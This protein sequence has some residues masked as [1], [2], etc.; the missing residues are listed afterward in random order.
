MVDD[1]RIV[2][3]ETKERNYSTPSGVR[4]GDTE[5]DAMRAYAGRA[6]VRPH[7]YTPSGHYLV[8]SDADGKRAVVVETDK[9]RVVA[10]RG[11]LKPAV[12]YVEGCS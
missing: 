7:K 6:E 1:G 11:G 8:V 4:V 10:I 5:E 9:G 3:V 12:E 2:R